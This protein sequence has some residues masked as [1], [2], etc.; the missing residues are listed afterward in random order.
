MQKVTR[1]GWTA[2]VMLVTTSPV[3][4]AERQPWT[5]QFTA[6][7]GLK[8]EAK[9]WKTTTFILGQ[10]FVLVFE[11]GM[12]TTESAAKQMSTNSHFVS[13]QRNNIDGVFCLDPN[14]AS[15]M[16]SLKTGKG[17]LSKIFTAVHDYPK[18]GDRLSVE[19]FSCQKD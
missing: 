13:C 1:V 10:P 16:L 12:L 11:D 6:S 18:S 8:G 3:A 17:A 19:H 7:A 5:C 2:V 14:G 9:K 4:M 15:L